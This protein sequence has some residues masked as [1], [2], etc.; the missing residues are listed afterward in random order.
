MV[1]L[2]A[3]VSTLDS[4]N[5]DHSKA[6][7]PR[8]RSVLVHSKPVMSARW[9]PVRKGSLAI[10]TG[11]GSMYVWSDEWEGEGGEL[12]EVAECVGVPAREFCT[13]EIRWAPDGKGLV[14]LDKETFCCAFEV[15]EDE[16]ETGIGAHAPAGADLPAFPECTFDEV[17]EN[18]DPETHDAPKNRFERLES[19]INELEAML[20]EK[21]KVLNSFNA[22]S[23]RLNLSSIFA[24]RQL[25][26]SFNSVHL[27]MLPPFGQSSTSPDVDMFH[28]ARGMDDNGGMDYP[29]FSGNSSLDNLA[30]VA[31]MLGT[32]PI[33]PQF[34]SD[35]DVNRGVANG[36][37]ARYSPPTGNLDLVFL[38]WPQNVPTQEVTHHLVEA[39]FA[40]WLHADR[41]FHAPTFMASLDLPPTHPKFPPAAVLHAICAIGSLYVADIA[42]V[43]HPPNDYAP[44]LLDEIFASRLRK[45]QRRPDSFAEQQAKY[46]K[47]AMEVGLDLGQNTF[48]C[49]QVCVMLTWF[50]WCHGRWSEAFLSAAQTLRVAV[51]CGLNACPPF[52]TIAETLRPPSILPPAKTV[53]EDEMRRNTFWLGYAMER[54]I[55]TGNG[56]A[57]S[58]DDQDVC[59]LL[60]VRMDQFVQGVLVY[61]QDRQWSHDKDVLTTHREQQTD[62]FILYIKATILLSRVKT[63]N[64]RFKGKHYVG[65][66]SI[67]SPNNSP[68]DGETPNLDNFDIKEAPAYRE[69][70]ASVL[71]YRAAFPQHLRDPVPSDGQPVDPY[72]YAAHLIPYLATILLHEPHARPDSSTCTHAGKI[73]K[74]SRSIVD[75]AYTV[76]ATSYDLSLLGLNPIMC[77]F[78]AA[79]VLIRFL[80]V[81]IDANSEQHIMALQGEIYFLR[82]VIGKAGDRLFL[83][84]RYRKMLDENL[85]AT[86]GQQFEETISTP[87]SQSVPDDF[88]SAMD[89]PESVQAHLDM[90]M[91]YKAPPPPRRRMQTLS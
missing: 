29:H 14:L 34:G 86:C 80:K 84:E 1:F 30:G 43:P 2:Y 71:A 23:A 81:A 58:L 26:T 68:A 46:A 55:G 82:T 39:F 31:S 12:E 22:E 3:F 73:L 59:Q 88:S 53:I 70:E 4:G 56:W 11:S 64:L 83:P 75:L 60:P 32:G 37:S 25:P 87:A 13:R 91:Q 52:H 47:Q 28:G 76:N 42:P 65:D 16:A 35:P 36:L 45:I 15:E 78:I 79:R 54:L 19:R 63:F 8:L 18:K 7:T 6:S 77:W 74:A 17:T 51:P 69:L 27:G 62:S 24:Q 10:C 67:V 40:F 85:F 38:A 57:L 20:R 49:V 5:D 66:A 48:Q 90:F 9:N 21:D 44:S 72:L 41:L 89:N 33:D 50:Y 61:P